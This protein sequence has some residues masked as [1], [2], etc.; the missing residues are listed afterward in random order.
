MCRVLNVS[1]SAFY[2]WLNRPV[3]NLFKEDEALK[4]MI[5]NIFSDSRETYGA[6]RVRQE[7][8]KEGYQVSRARVGKLMKHLNLKCKASKKY[9]ATTN[10]KHALP[11]YPNLLNREFN[12]SGPNKAY[13][14][15]IT[16]IWTEEGWM[17]LAVLI[18]LYSRMVVGWSMSK[19]MKANLVVSALE[20]AVKKRS[21]LKGLIVHS[22]RGSQYASHAYQ[23]LISKYDFQCSMS[24]KGNCWD[25]APAESFFKTLKSDLIYHVRFKTR[26]EA[27]AAI[28]EYIEVFY[29]RQRQHSNLNY[30]TPV[31]YEEANAA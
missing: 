19:R 28:F 23:R 27:E 16:Y 6:R 7:L 29:N 15:D 22:D 11:V 1:K 5:S 8:R 17:Y 12:V 30:L 4:P 26:E 31:E 21:P 13:V 10:S 9:K 14:G 25:N 3:S 2:A 18:D 20:M 24:R